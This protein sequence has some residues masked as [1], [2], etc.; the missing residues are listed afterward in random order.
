MIGRFTLVLGFVCASSVAYAQQPQ[1]D[2][3]SQ[4]DVTAATAAAAAAPVAAAA[5][6]A[7]ATAP[8]APAAPAPTPVVPRDRSTVDMAKQYLIGPEDVLDVTVWKNC[9]DL[10]RTV[11]VRPDGK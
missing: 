7:V 2:A 10:C 5:L 9:P 8:A 6:D 3:A 1:T 4:P 11:P